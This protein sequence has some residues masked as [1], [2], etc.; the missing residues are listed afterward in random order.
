MEPQ[1]CC[2]RTVWI[3]QQKR[4]W[5]QTAG[6]SPDFQIWIRPEFRPDVSTV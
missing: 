6:H 1:L 3:K 4:P 5:T 2:G